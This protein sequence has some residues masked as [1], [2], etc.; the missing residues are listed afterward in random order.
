MDFQQLP[1]NTVILNRPLMKK[2]TQFLWGACLAMTVLMIFPQ[3]ASARTVI[4]CYNNNE[5][6]CYWPGEWCDMEE[7]GCEFDCYPTGPQ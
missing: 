2:L 7:E 1:M 4:I 3:E 5:W 6:C